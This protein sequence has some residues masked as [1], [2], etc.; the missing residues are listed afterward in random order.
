MITCAQLL[1]SLVSRG[2]LAGIRADKRFE[3]HFDELSA[4]HLGERRMVDNILLLGRWTLRV[5]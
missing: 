1:T 2:G 3:L 4:D 5:L